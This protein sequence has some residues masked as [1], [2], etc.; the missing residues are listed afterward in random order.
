VSPDA[1]RHD[2]HALQ[3]PGNAEVQLAL[4]RDYPSNV[5]LYPAVHQYFRETQSPLLAVWGRNDLIFV[6]AGATAFQR[7]PARRPEVQLID[8]GHWLLESH[9]D[10]VAGYKGSSAG[11]CNTG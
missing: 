7:D 8:G 6:P 3:R 5:R 4:Y 10:T 11:C 9:L 2:F 1:W